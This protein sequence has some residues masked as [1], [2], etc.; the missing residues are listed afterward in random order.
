[1]IHAA[2]KREPQIRKQVVSGTDFGLHDTWDFWFEQKTTAQLLAL[3]YGIEVVCANDP[4]L[5]SFLLSC[6][7][8]V[9]KASSYLDEDQIKV[10]YIKGKE[11]A[12]PFAQFSGI[13]HRM[14]PAQLDLAQAYRR[15]KVRFDVAVGDARSLPIAD[16]SVDRVITSPPYINAVDYTM[17]HKYNLFLL[18]LVA[19]ATFKSHCRDYIG[20]TE[21]AV[22]TKDHSSKP[23]ALSK[24]VQD[25][26]DRIWSVGTATACNRSFIVATYFDGML[27]AFQEMARTLKS[28]GKVVLVVGET[29]RICGIEVPTAD[30]LSCLSQ[31]AG[32]TVDLQFRHELANRSSMRLNRSSTGGVVK[33]ER[34][35]VLRNA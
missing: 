9:L 20:M 30:L 17:A 11:I 27:R 12:D 13:V 3:R 32:F 26:V 24:R 35:L 25:I 19:P 7:S 15:R 6:L 29:N 34:V 10:R 18:G 21:R 4:G 31:E 22:R 2:K 5:R 28:G 23:E 16:R 33:C 14:L 1:V 8:S